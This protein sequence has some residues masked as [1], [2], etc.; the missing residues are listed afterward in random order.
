MG[1]TFYAKLVKGYEKPLMKNLYDFVS[2]DSQYD[3]KTVDNENP[4]GA[5]VTKALNFI[6]N[7]AENDGFTVKN[8]ANKV[9][10]ILC[11][12]G[13]KNITIMSHADI[14][15]EGKGWTHDPFKIMEKRGI[16]YGRGVADDKG[17]CLSAYYALKAL[18]DNNLLGNYQVRFLVG[19]NEEK[20]SACMEYYFKTLK[21]PQPTLGFS[22]DSSFPVV[23]AEKNMSSFKVCKKISV[24]GIISVKGGSVINAVIDTCEVKV[25]INCG[26]LQY[27]LSNFTNKEANIVTKDDISTITFYGKA[28][29]G[30]VPSLGINAGVIALKALAGYY[31]SQ[32]LKDFVSKID[33]L[34]G[35]SFNAYYHDKAGDST[36]NVGVINWEN[37][38]L[39]LLMDF[40]YFSDTALSVI[41]RR[42]VKAFDREKITFLVDPI[43][44]YFSPKSK[45]ITTL[46]ES[47]QQ[48]TGDLK[49]KPQA[50]GG[51][52]YAKEASN[53]VAYGMEF[54][55]FETNMHGVDEKIQ[56]ESLFK[57]MAI[58][59]NAI[60][61]LGKIL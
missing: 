36:S 19:G 4:F 9:V 1:K 7:L 51:G 40:R 57:G 14:V 33:S 29:H 30:S 21:K 42:I 18:R 10:E 48:E 31:N 54:P 27:I 49:S 46:I 61:A 32:N 8:Y 25:D 23:Y 20:G 55:G 2:I 28:A 53:V 35:S 43:P 44:L 45:L 22:P 50:I 24:P 3:E 60:I 56:K 38:N 41:R 39:E 13:D 52:T 34:D 15:P 26:F 6:A 37:G 5:G 59:A 47:Y 11:G 12:S 17:P 58:Y 16:L